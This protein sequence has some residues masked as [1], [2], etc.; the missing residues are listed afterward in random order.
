MAS[1]IRSIA[2]LTALTFAQ[3]TLASDWFSWQDPIGDDDGDGALH[4]PIKGGLATGDL[5]VRS[6]SAQKD[7]D[8]VWFRVVF[9]Q[10]IANPETATRDGPGGNLANL[11]RLG[12]YAFNLD[13]YFDLDQTPGSGQVDTLP[14]RDITID[15]QSAWE[16][17]VIVTPRPE[18]SRDQ[19]VDTRLA[20]APELT[21]A[22]VEAEID[23]RVLFVSDVRVQGNVLRF[24]VPLAFLGRAALTSPV[25]LVAFV[26]PAELNPPLSSLSLPGIS[27][28]NVRPDPSFRLG[29]A[30][31]AQGGSGEAYQ[32]LNTK[33]TPLPIIDW[34]A[35]IDQHA[36]LALR[37]PLPG[38]IV[39]P[40]QAP[41]MAAMT[42]TTNTAKPRPP[43]APP[44]ATATVSATTPAPKVS[45]PAQR[46]TAAAAPIA[47]TSAP[48]AQTAS[49]TIANTLEN[50]LRLLKSLYEQG[51]IDADEYKTNKQN[52]LDL[53]KR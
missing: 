1:W 13:L 11:A 9:R 42:A 51:L 36:L 7:G 24:K 23:K 20:Q 25:G 15:P 16:R 30:A 19:W 41:K 37:R 4:Y 32:Y 47:P 22:L 33:E 49:G 3:A 52:L 12:F 38:V 31:V 26:T 5:D 50:K 8:A 35:P 45:P 6:L 39:A 34:I 48:A 40:G 27:M 43:V 18:F 10:P 53:L 14:G 2:I 21:R 29:V 46:D 44:P 28:S 17:A